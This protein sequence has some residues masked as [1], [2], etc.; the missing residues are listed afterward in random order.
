MPINLVCA[1]ARRFNVF[2]REPPKSWTQPGNER[3]RRNALNLFADAPRQD[4]SASQLS[5]SLT[6]LAKTRS[7]RFPIQKGKFLADP[8]KSVY[9]PQCSVEFQR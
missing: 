7:W 6:C 5:A 1:K 2:K 8:K 4:R 3:R 9:P